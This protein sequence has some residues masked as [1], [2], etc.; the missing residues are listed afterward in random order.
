MR[1]SVSFHESLAEAYL[2]GKSVKAVAEAFGCSSVTV[3]HSIKRQG[4][5][6]RSNRRMRL[7][8]SDQARIRELHAE[9]GNIL[10]IARE[11]G[12][13]KKTVA[14][15]LHLAGA[16]IRKG[17]PR[18]HSPELRRQLAEAYAEGKSS[19]VVAKEF[20]VSEWAVFH[21]VCDNGFS[22]RS[23]GASFKTFPREVIEEIVRAYKAG[24]SQSQ[25]GKRFGISQPTVSNI[26]RVEGVEIV[27]ARIRK[28]E[29]HPS[30]KGGRTITGEGYVRVYSSE[31][32]SMTTSSGYIP[33]H[34]LVMARSLG[35]ALNR[36]ETVHHK[37][38]NRADN[39]LENLELRVGQHGTGATHAHCPTCTCFQH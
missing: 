15:V 26:L 1:Y 4:I 13:G 2:S 14:K 38:G 17:G 20:G 10:S 19:T 23:P 25:V 5:T 21:A 29:R 9:G 30:W 36:H 39:R 22:I 11:T 32:P 12:L 37:N 35:R 27:D 3:W 7:T 18:K 6:P 24:D 34:R 28:G 16:E 31:F 33:E 8:E